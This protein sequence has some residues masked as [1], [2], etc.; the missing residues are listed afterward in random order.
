MGNSQAIETAALPHLILAYLALMLVSLLV[1]VVL[2]LSQRTRTTLLNILYWV[3]GTTGFAVQGLANQDPQLAALALLPTLAIVLV[4][5][6]FMREI[7]DYALPL[8]LYAGVLA[9]SALLGF[10]ALGFDL[11]FFAT[12]MP[13]CA[14]I[15]MVVLHAIW[16]I[17]RKRPP[18]TI[19]G[20]A[21]LAILALWSLHMLDYPW[22]RLMPVAQSFGFMAAF[23]FACLLSILMPAVLLEKI[24]FGYQDH[25]RAEIAAATHDILQA[26]QEIGHM[27]EVKTNLL[28]VLSHDIRNTLAVSS[29]FFHKYDRLST[30]LKT[31]PSLSSWSALD[32]AARRG[33]SVLLN[34][35]N[36]ITSVQAAQVV[37]DGKATP[38]ASTASLGLCLESARNLFEHRLLEKRLQLIVSMDGTDRIV[39]D[40][41]LLTNNVFANLL[42]NAVKFS[43]PDSRISITARRHGDFV[44]VVVED[45]GI[46]IPAALLPDLFKYS[47]TTTRQGTQGERGSGYGMPILKQTMDLCGASVSVDSVARGESSHRS[48]TVFRLMFLAAPAEGHGQLQTPRWP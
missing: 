48:G 20:R 2:H 34:L 25:L 42:S 23:V 4:I 43:D 7:H 32:A 8:G 40:E 18:G 3:L 17:V 15:A 37:Q 30:E 44:E 41:H 11:N 19:A 38:L 13:M 45:H 46:G 5:L 22:L 36:F 35:T 33:K 29:Y 47:A 31:S 16:T 9:G 6:A 14:G 12:T 27:Y 26:K 39:G 24:Q 10:V 1:A 21:F 28:R